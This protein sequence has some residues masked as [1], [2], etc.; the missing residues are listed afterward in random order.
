MKMDIYTLYI[1]LKIPLVKNN[2]YI[3]KWLPK[4]VLEEL[5]EID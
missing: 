5:E 2:I 3:Y 4:E 1:L